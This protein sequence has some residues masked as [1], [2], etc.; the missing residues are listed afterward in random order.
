MKERLAHGDLSL[1]EPVVGGLLIRKSLAVIGAPD[2]SFKTNWATQL[3]ISLIKGIPSYSF[4]CKPSV[5]AY[6]VLEG[7]TDYIYERIDDKIDAMGLNRDEIIDKLYVVDCSKQPLDEEAVSADIE[8][9][10]NNLDPKPDVVIFDPITYAINE[11][12]RFS[13]KKAALCKN[14]I[15]IAESLNGVVL[16]VIHCRKGTQNNISTDDFIGSSIVADM[17][18]TRIKLFREENNVTMFI[19]T[20]YA[21][22]PDAIKLTWAK[23]LLNVAHNVLSER[24]ECNISTIEFLTAKSDK[25]FILGDLVD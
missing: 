5:V 13:P 9:S 6:M 14:L 25:T 10:L 22:R 24:A 12:V 8:N 11:D 16:A 3:A 1:P 19:K 7:V 17:A 21:E 20:R 15:R 2:D 18:A 23:P 4:N